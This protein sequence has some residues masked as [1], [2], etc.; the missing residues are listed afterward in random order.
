MKNTDYIRHKALIYQ[1]YKDNFDE[2]E[3]VELNQFRLEIERA[4]GSLP[5]SEIQIIFCDGQP[6]ANHHELTADIRNNKQMKISSDFNESKLLPGML[7]LQ[8]RAIHDYLHYVL[9]APFTA[10]GEITVYNIQKKLHC[11]AIGQQ[12]LFSEVVLQ[13]CYAEYF[14]TEGK[15]AF[16]PVQKV[17]LYK[18]KI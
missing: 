14:G 9:Q 16:A 18:G 13:A 2:I 17:I 15:P 7:N 5:H 11:S 8:F 10:E 4:Y 1:R 3:T 6:Y 12:I